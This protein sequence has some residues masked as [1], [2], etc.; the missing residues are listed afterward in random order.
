MD[1]N[2]HSA[3]AA[4]IYDVIYREV[5]KG[6]NNPTRSQDDA[7]TLAVLIAKELER[8]YKLKLG[9]RG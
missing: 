8:V 1:A 6:N 5:V 7:G 9:R 4:T 3:V 2:N